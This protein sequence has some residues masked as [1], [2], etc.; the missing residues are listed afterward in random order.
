MQ[1]CEKLECHCMIRESK[2]TIWDPHNK[3]DRARGME[4]QKKITEMTGVSVTIWCDAFGGQQGL[5]QATTASNKV[6]RAI[7]ESQ[8]LGNSELKLIAV[9]DP[10]PSSP[11]LYAPAVVEA[12]CP[13]VFH[14]EESQDPVPAVHDDLKGVYPVRM[15]RADLLVV[16]C[17]DQSVYDDLLDSVVYTKECPVYFVSAQSF[18]DHN[19][20]VRIVTRGGAPV[21]QWAQNIV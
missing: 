13:K 12:M 4:L 1:A 9:S 20:T 7:A 21:A 6:E 3:L 16:K 11:P 8:T 17:A 15:K 5:Q 19:E 18:R 14:D 2:L 10:D